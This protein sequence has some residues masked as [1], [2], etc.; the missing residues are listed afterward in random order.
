MSQQQKKLNLAAR[1]EFAR[2]LQ[3][4][5]IEKGFNQAELARRMQEQLPD[6]RIERDTISTYIRAIAKPSPHRLVIIAQVLGKD[7]SELLPVDV[8]P[9]AMQ[10][11]DNVPKRE[12]KDMGDGNVWLTV[13]QA[14]EFATALKVLELLK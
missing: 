13:N 6:E 9:V 1:K 7:V 2:R 3:A 5:M 12:I 4:A 14:V 8:L 10:P 11:Q